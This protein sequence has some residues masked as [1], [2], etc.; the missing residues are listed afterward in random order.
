MPSLSC[1]LTRQGAQQSLSF[2]LHAII[3][4]RVLLAFPGSGA[5]CLPAGPKVCGAALAYCIIT[6][7]FVRADNSRM[8]VS[9]EEQGFEEEHTGSARAFEATE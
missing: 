8:H 3:P 4:A 6:H 7:T 5:H 2:L 9:P 1:R